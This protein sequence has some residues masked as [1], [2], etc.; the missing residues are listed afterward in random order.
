M[1]CHLRQ[2]RLVCIDT[3]ID[4][5]V[6]VGNLRLGGR[7]RSALHAHGGADIA[8]EGPLVC[9]ASSV[10]VAAVAEG[11]D[12]IGAKFGADG[13]DWALASTC[14]IPARCV[15][16]LPGLRVPYEIVGTLRP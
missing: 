8:G 16:R 5:P 11:G 9:P 14:A 7:V 13:C 15:D 3:S 4:R 2:I 10:G 1:T 6:A 12:I